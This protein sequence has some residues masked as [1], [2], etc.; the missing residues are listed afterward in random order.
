MTHLKPLK[1]KPRLRLG[2]TLIELLVVIA[3][4]AILAAMLLPALSAA[5]L[6]AQAILC[7]ANLKQ[8]VVGFHLYAGDHNDNM[9]LGW[10]DPN[11]MWMV[12]L[13]PYMPGVTNGVGMGGKLCFCPV[14]TKVRSDLGGNTWTTSGTTF[15]A[16]GIMGQGAYNV[17]LPWG[18]P[19]M[20][21]S[22]GCNG[23]VA[24]PASG[25]VPAT[26]AP[27]YWRTLTGAGKYSTKTP[28]FADCVWPGANPHA[29]GMYNS[30]PSLD[31]P[32]ANLGDCQ[33]GAEMPA[34]CVVRHP[35]RNPVNMAFV[36]G[37]ARP[38]GLRQ[39]W[40][41]PWSRTYDP[42]QA[43]SKFYPWLNSFN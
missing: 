3:I 17:S 42:S 16:W 32:P 7:T 33:V 24:N 6:R 20:A 9:M 5:K 12:A 15:L 28:L 21:G 29:G 19:G 40:Q 4:I 18:R 25:T 36:D 31:A 1:F 38:V 37:S 30:S 10:G 35:G 34:F 27:G 22:Y 43:V 41:L 39:L 23:W 14:A 26:D 2:F 13:Q 8:W 11:G